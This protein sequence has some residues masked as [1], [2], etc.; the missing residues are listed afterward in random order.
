MLTNLYFQLLVVGV[1]GVLVANPVVPEVRQGHAQILH[2]QMVDPCVLEI[3]VK[4]VTR[5][6]VLVR[7]FLFSTRIYHL[8]TNLYLQLM[9]VGV[10]GEVVANPVV[11]EVR[12]E[13]AQILEQHSEVVV[14]LDLQ[15][16][17]ATLKHVLV[18]TF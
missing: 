9:V 18:M 12:Q 17:L 4:L 5:K 11:P 13:H 16:K 3:Q 10:L 2:Q 15:V 14:V 8:L 6:H 7:F 1:L